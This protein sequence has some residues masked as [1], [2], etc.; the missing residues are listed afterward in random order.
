MD[1]DPTIRLFLP[2]CGEQKR[3]VEV[4]CEREGLFSVTNPAGCPQGTPPP[5]SILGWPHFLCSFE[6]P[7]ST[8]GGHMALGMLFS[9]TKW[10]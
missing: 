6:Y 1:Q 8:P 4:E 7:P 3:R 5:T 10:D 2:F 9:L